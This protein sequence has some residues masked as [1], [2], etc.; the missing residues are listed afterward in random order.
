MMDKKKSPFMTFIMGA[1]A[2]AAAVFLSDERNRLKMQTK[3]AEMKLNAKEKKRELE[4]KLTKTKKGTRK[5]LVKR[6]E[7]ARR[8][9][10]E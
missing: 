4:R 1:A 10:E 3:L 9:L 2:G 7:D 5:E 6:L 8:R